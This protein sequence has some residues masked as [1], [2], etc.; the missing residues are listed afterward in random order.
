M[1]IVTV[2]VCLLFVN[3]SSVGCGGRAPRIAHSKIGPSNRRAHAGASKI[4]AFDPL[5][6]ESGMYLV[7]VYANRAGCGARLPRVAHSQKMGPQTGEYAPGP[8]NVGKV[9]WSSVIVY[10]C[11]MFVNASSVGCCGRAPCIAYSQNRASNRQSHAG[12]LKIPAFDTLTVE[13]GMCLVLGVVS[14][15][16]WGARLTRIAYSQ[17]WD[18]ESTA[19]R[20]RAQG[21]RIRHHHRTA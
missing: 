9:A 10:A 13:S 16:G 12:A 14:R 2:Y 7:L 21:S 19:A 18:P 5:T 4:L 8:S 20:R 3:A 1:S 11:S 17:K 15:A 6:V